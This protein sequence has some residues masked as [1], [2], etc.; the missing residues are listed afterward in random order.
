MRRNVLTWLSQQ[1]TDASHAIILTHNIDFLFVQGVLVPRLRWAG[2]PRLTI[3]ADVNCA[4]GA[5][6]DQRLLLDGLGVRYRVVAVDLGPMR[7]FHAKAILLINRQRAVCAIGSGNLTHGGMSANHEV[8]TFGASDGEGASLLAGLRDYINSLTAT[9]PIA[10]PVRDSLEAVFDREQAW[11]A[12]LPAPSG[13]ALS[14]AGQPLLDQIAAFAGVGIQSI[15]VLAPYFDDDGAALA[16]IRHRF[17]VPVTV[18]IQ[19]GRE[20]LS[21]K[22]AAALP[23]GISLKTI[24]CME[25]RRPS[26]IHA[27]MLAFHR[28]EDVVLAVGSANCSRAALLADR[29]WSNAELMVVDTITP[30]AFAQFFSE[31]TPTDAFPVLP[32]HPPSDEW[33]L[34]VPPLRILAARQ[35]GNRLDVAFKSAELLSTLVVEAEEGVWQA[36]QLDVKGGLAVFPISLRLRSI[37]LAGTTISGERL[38][39]AEAWVDDETSLAAPASLRRIFR[40][41]Q[42]TESSSQDPAEDFRAVLDQFRDYLRDPEVARRRMRRHVES[43]APPS[44]YDPASVFSDE[45]GRGGAGAPRQTDFS[46]SQQSVLSIIE[47]LFAISSGVGGTSTSPPPAGGSGEEPDPNAEEERLISRPKQMPKTKV[48]AQL[49]RALEGVEAAL[50]DP[51]FIAARRPELLG[52]DIALAAILL[53][54]GLADGYLEV[55]AYRATTRK[56]WVELFFGAQGDGTGSIA[57]RLQELDADERTKFIAAF[58]SP[59]LSAA[60]ILWSLPEWRTNDPEALWFRM[61]AGQ[62]HHRQPWLFASASPE[63]VIAELLSQAALLPP[64]ERELAMAAWVDLVR[65]GEALRLLFDSLTRIPHINLVR[66]VTSAEVGVRDLLW[67]ANALAF[68]LRPY[69]RES[70]VHAEVLVLGEATPRKFKGNHLVPVRDLFGS[71]IIQLHPRA[72]EEIRRFIEAASAVQQH[73]AHR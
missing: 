23:H 60:L 16:E 7:R 11:V 57:R 30:A 47:A 39:S 13:L 63:E 9:L 37:K 31:L 33:E 3:F 62:L 59:K 43:D 29:N 20:G 70:G 10:E 72:R 24:N 54:K 73:A 4:A 32:E 68:P 18:W 26:F 58:A 41:L 27:K 15:S 48:V 56:L 44:P 61:S 71:K 49:R 5:Y 51:A 55:D 64:D 1:F 22:A 25:D 19:P 6:R 45:F 36:S 65:C 66:E 28:A 8:W 52:A 12:D 2:N 69:R 21:S 67:Q 50:L 14:P 46:R 35:E 40:R 17:G 34:E 42:D 38:T 53:V